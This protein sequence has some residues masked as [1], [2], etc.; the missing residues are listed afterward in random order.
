MKHALVMVHGMGEH[1]EA[2]HEPA[3]SVLSAA[4]KEYAAFKGRSLEDLVTPVPI[5]YSRFLSELRNQWKSDVSKIK[6]TLGTELSKVD[7]SEKKRVERAIDSVADKIGAGADTFAWTHA[8]DVVLY[9]FFSLTRHRI[10]VSV[11]NQIIPKATTMEFDGWS[12]LAHSLGT[13]VSHNVLHALYT[14]PLIDGQ[15]PLS[16]LESR[17]K[18]LAMIA[19]VSRV[20]QLPDLKVYS[21]RVAPGSPLLGRVCQTYLNVRHQWDPF[22]VPQ[23]FK[24]D[25]GWPDSLIFDSRQYQ[26]I[27]PSH[28]IIEK[29]S[30]VHAL[31]HYLRNPRVHVPL[32]RAIFGEDEIPDNEYCQAVRQFDSGVI[33]ENTNAIRNVLDSLL[34]ASSSQWPT[35]LSTGFKLFGKGRVS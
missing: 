22:T 8:M 5:N 16:T 29:Y 9:R 4:F 1:A 24:P 10:N 34:P 3:M 32:F 26:H 25:P 33:D 17:P 13:S 31:D 30:E 14:T 21:S 7:N 6:I 12:V 35:L 27:C 15:P 28:L 19:N 23:P 11:A 18:V 20:L 2:W